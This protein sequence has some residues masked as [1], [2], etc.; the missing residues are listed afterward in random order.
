[1]WQ[2]PYLLGAELSDDQTR[3]LGPV[4]PP[5]PPGPYVFETAI[6]EKLRGVAE[7]LHRI[8]VRVRQGVNTSGLLKEVARFGN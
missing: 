1:M 2:E 8:G 4:L 5:R 3:V 6:A 7:S